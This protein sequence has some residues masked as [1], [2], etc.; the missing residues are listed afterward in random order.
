MAAVLL[1]DDHDHAARGSG[2]RW[3]ARRR[4]CRARA[5][6]AAARATARRGRSRARPPSRPTEPSCSAS[7]NCRSSGQ[8]GEERDL[9][10]AGV[11]EDRRQL[12]AAQH[13]ERRVAHGVRAGHDVNRTAKRLDFYRGGLR[14]PYHGGYGDVTPSGHDGR[15]PALTRPAPASRSRPRSALAGG[16]AAREPG[17]RIGTEQELADEFGVSRPTMR[18]ALRL[19]SASHLI[20]VGRGRS[21]GIFVARTPSEGM[22]RNVSRVDRAD[23]GRREHLDGRAARRAPVA[24]GADRGP[25]RGQRRRRRRATAWRRRSRTRSG[26]QPGTRAVQRRRQPL[27]R[28]SS[29]RRRATSCCSR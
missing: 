17:E 10:R 28:R 4:R 5:S 6:S 22:S 12:E 26:H 23:A 11:R 7:T 18:E 20:R 19:L 24:R 15:V 29:P 13:V 3:R 16:A 27:P 9:G 1:A 21:G 2:A 14:I 8:P 25:R